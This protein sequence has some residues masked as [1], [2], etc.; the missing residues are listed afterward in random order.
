MDG[1]KQDIACQSHF[2]EIDDN[3]GL[4]AKRWGMMDNADW[5]GMRDDADWGMRDEGPGMVE[6]MMDDDDDSI[7]HFPAGS[8]ALWCK[9]SQY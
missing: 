7:A 2:I 5:W 1:K 3:W 4:R 6:W 9:H 8:N